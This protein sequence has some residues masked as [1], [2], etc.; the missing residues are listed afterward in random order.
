MRIELTVPR[1]ETRGW[2]VGGVCLLWLLVSLLGYRMTQ[3]MP[4]AAWL[5]RSR[6]QVLHVHRQTRHDLQRLHRDL[7]ELAALSHRVHPDPAQ[8]L[9]LAQRIYYRH[10]TGAVTTAATRHALIQA[11]T[12]AVRVSYGAQA[13]E[14]LASALHS[15]EGQLQH[16]QFP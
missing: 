10:R 16:L 3:Q 4:E 7:R 14:E 11:A 15:V 5:T 12:I 1:T 2:I 9:T 8:T 6:W 13:P